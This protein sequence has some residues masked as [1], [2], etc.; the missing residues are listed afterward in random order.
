M[1]GGEGEDYYYFYF[2]ARANSKSLHVIKREGG[3]GVSALAD[4]T[5][6]FCPTSDLGLDLEY[7][8]HALLIAC[9]CCFSV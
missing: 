9:C 3:G 4:K 2:F 1:G 8:N 6:P 7:Q 5:Q